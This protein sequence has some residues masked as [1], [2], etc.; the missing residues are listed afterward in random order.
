MV[1]LA[2]VDLSE[3]GAP[4]QVHRPSRCTPRS[5]SSPGGE[6]RIERSSL[7]EEQRA[8][9]ALLLFV[10]FDSDADAGWVPSD[11]RI[12]P[13]MR[14]CAG[15]SMSCEGERLAGRPD[16]RPARRSQQASEDHARSCERMT[17]CVTGSVDHVD[18]PIRAS[19]LSRVVTRG[20]SNVIRA[21]EEHLPRRPLAW[22][23][24]C[25]LRPPR[26]QLAWGREALTGPGRPRA[27]WT[28]REPG[29]VRPGP[30]RTPD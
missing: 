17:I 26:V 2:A 3:N 25:C 30:R 11:A 7:I 19:G 6:R 8:R 1:N 10:H 9:A 13:A 16:D 24:H 28:F 21:A 14:A 23:R 4:R 20:C 29:Q 27:Y 15:P 5:A 12:A 18:D 22:E